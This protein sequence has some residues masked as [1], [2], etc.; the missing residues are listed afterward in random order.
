VDGYI[1]KLIHKDYLCINVTNKKYNEMETEMDIVSVSKCESDSES[2]SEIENENYND[3]LLQTCKEQI[4]DLQKFVDEL[5]IS[6]KER[7]QLSETAY[8]LICETIQSEPM[9]YI[10]PNF[11]E[12]LLE[13]VSELLIQQLGDIFINMDYIRETINKCV[14][15]A[16]YLFYKK[17]AP[18]RSYK[19]TTPS[20]YTEEIMTAKIDYLK[21]VPQ[22]EQRT[23]EWYAFRQN[24]LTASNIWK[25]FSTPSTN[26]QLIYEKC[27][28]FDADKY[29]N[30]FTNTSSPMHWGQRFESVSVMYYESIYN[31]KVGDFGCV[32]HKSIKCL[33]ASPDG[34][35]ISKGTG[36]Y[37]RMLEIKNIV[38]RVIDGVPK[39]EYWI[40]M[41]VQMEVCDL[42]ECDFLETRFVEYESEDAFIRD[43]S[44]SPFHKGLIMYFN[45][46][47]KPLYEYSKWGATREEIEVWENAMLEKHSKL[48][49]VQNIYW[50][51]T[52]ISCVLVLR[53]KLWFD[54]AKPMIENT[55]E[56]I[57][58]EKE[59]GEY[60]KREPKRKTNKKTF[61]SATKSSCLIDT[62]LFNIC[63]DNVCEEEYTVYDISGSEI[64]IIPEMEEGEA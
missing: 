17:F 58:K 41:Q 49:V 47:G 26:N 54:A 11:H 55:W 42:D 9:L 14:E 60:V 25:V 10:N 15:V 21:S 33:A 50:K 19:N 45:D 43:F 12:Q 18:I 5:I 62:N 35:N 57:V 36:R 3:I 51:L 56:V 31:T 32:P 6:D 53:N 22:P 40:Q 8:N 30:T 13:Q 28:P 27:S 16:L 44:V 20:F 52:E 1:K 61:A 64:D 7:T 37:G 23:P 34:I 38:N 63:E 2:G 48:V 46:G 39:M 24:V 29:N 4:D 59:S